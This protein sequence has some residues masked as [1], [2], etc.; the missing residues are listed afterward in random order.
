MV[1][2]TARNHEKYELYLDLSHKGAQTQSGF[3]PVPADISLRQGNWR[4]YLY[5]GCDWSAV[6]RSVH[7]D[8]TKGEKNLA[9]Y[10]YRIALK[11]EPS[12]KMCVHDDETAFAHKC[13]R[14]VVSQATIR[15]RYTYRESSLP[16]RFTNA[17]ILHWAG[18]AESIK[19]AIRHVFGLSNTF[20]VSHYRWSTLFLVVFVVDCAL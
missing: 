9:T 3:P 14:A 12:I 15:C 10:A 20:I 16:I 18:S 13:T 19:Y 5:A 7:Y 17:P 2:R 8:K 4:I 1:D 11:L 6:V